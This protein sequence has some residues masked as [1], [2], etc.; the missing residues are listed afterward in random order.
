[1]VT[2]PRTEQIRS[3]AAETFGVDESEITDDASAK[4]IPQWTSFNHLTLMSS[5]EETLGI[6][7]SMEEMTEL[8][9]FSD[10]IDLVKK[11]TE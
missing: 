11:H 8:K 6:T 1:M 3:I 9:T 5:V 4:T 2:D 7:F 10:L